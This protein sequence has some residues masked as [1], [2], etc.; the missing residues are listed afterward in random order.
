MAAIHLPSKQGPVMLTM[1]Q[2][3]DNAEVVAHVKDG[4]QLHD[5]G[6]I[7]LSYTFDLFE[8][9]LYPHDRLH[10]RV[11]Y[12]DEMLHSNGPPC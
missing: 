3:A 6:M 1:G 9:L 7:Q 12:L 10:D 4:F 2:V 11:A 5:A 8:K